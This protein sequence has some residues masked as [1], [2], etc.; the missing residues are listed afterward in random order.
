MR[1]HDCARLRADGGSKT[2]NVDIGGLEIDVHEDRDAAV[3]DDG[4]DGGGKSGGDGDDFAAFRDAP[5]VQLPG[6][7]RRK[8]EK[9][10]GRARHR[11]PAMRE[12]EPRR[13]RRLEFGRVTA[14]GEPQIER[15]VEKI[16][17]VGCIENLAGAGDVG[18]AGNEA[19]AGLA[20][21]EEFLAERQDL[22]A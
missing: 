7:Q 3:L 9:I 19:P 12:A 16:A 1:E 18:L 6:C 17:Q 5:L 14:G 10:G 21:G 20:G 13:Q 8:G 11:E 15:G 4:G 2:L 22:L